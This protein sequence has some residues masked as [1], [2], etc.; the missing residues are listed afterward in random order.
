M[1]PWQHMKMYFGNIYE[2]VATIAV[3]M[4]ITFKTA[5]FERKVTIQY[6]SHDV[7]EGKARDAVTFP[8][9]ELNPPFEPFLGASQQQ[10][11]GPLQA[12]IADRYRGFLGYR[13]D[14]CISCNL[15][16]QACPIEVIAVE[17]VKIE[18]RKGR[19]PVMFRI[20]Y[21]KC[22]FCGLCVEV[23]PTSAIFFTRRFAAA[24]FSYHSLI[25][26]FISEEMRQ[27]RLELA[28]QLKQK[29]RSKTIKRNAK[30]ETTHF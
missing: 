1:K 3:G 8:E 6:P 18:G 26:N 4:W 13:E 12:R 23:C 16:V 28:R 27:Q 30:D 24:T 5:F 11:R 10:Y 21:S 15:C 14:K 20:D 25:E 29:K 2:A 9:Q 19:A 7:L 22:M 17:G